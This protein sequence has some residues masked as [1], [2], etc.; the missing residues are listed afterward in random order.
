MPV[1]IKKHTSVS[2]KLEKKKTL[3]EICVGFK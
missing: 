3:S 2:L 1:F